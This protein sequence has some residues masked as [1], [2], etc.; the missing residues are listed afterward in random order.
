MLSKSL[1]TLKLLHL[2]YFV[3]M[4]AHPKP[5]YFSYDSIFFSCKVIIGQNKAQPNLGP[6]CSMFNFA[7]TS[8]NIRC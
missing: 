8:F 5:E 3:C 7:T 1:V 2:E 6:I 4:L